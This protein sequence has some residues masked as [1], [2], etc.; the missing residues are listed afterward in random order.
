MTEKDRPATVPARL[1]TLT[2]DPLPPSRD[3]RLSGEFSGGECPGCQVCVY[4]TRVVPPGFPQ[5]WGST[6]GRRVH[7]MK[8]SVFLVLS[9]SREILRVMILVVP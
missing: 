3:P 2:G 8:N 7:D 9:D 1:G 5:G 4:I 6:L